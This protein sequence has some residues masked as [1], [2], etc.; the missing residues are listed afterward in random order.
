[1]TAVQSAKAAA[2]RAPPT[3]MHAHHPPPHQWEESV[4]LSAKWAAERADIELAA[5]LGKS[6]RAHRWLVWV[7]QQAQQ[8]KHNG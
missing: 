8:E 7:V 2:Y 5:A 6:D 4:I 3:H 1:M